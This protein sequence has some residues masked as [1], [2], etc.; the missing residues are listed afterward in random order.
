MIVLGITSGEFKSLC[1]LAR[2][3]LL[4]FVVFFYKR[5]N[6]SKREG[7]AGEWVKKSGKKGRK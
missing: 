1:D 3:G 5:G 2:A 6:E 7:Y 4:F